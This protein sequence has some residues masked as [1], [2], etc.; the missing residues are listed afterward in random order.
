MRMHRLHALALAALLSTAACGDIP[1]D[2]PDAQ[3]VIPDAG[4][5]RTLLG[6]VT[7]HV[8]VASR[9]EKCGDLA[10][11]RGPSLTR[12]IYGGTYFTLVVGAAWHDSGLQRDNKFIQI[13]NNLGQDIGTHNGIQSDSIRAFLTNIATT[14]G[15][16]VVSANNHTGTGTFTASNQ[17]Y[18][19][20]REIVSANGGQSGTLQWVFNV[21]NT[22]TSWTY[23]VAL[24]APIAHPNG[25]VDVTGNDQIPH[26]GTR[27]HTAVVYDWT[28]AVDNTGTV[29]WSSTDVSGSVYVSPWDQRVG[30]VLGVRIGTA[31]VTASKGSATPQ[32][33]GVTV[34]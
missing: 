15:T 34:S 17:P 3:A 11:P 5:D 2:A 13:Q 9:T 29:S 28:G 24:S 25:W 23:T 30:T 19:E 14:G 27:Q 18:W 26:S 20:Y 12:V 16:G 10:R 31:E 21:P 7:C 8:D 6:S 22:V 32:T 33:Y 4:A 1:T